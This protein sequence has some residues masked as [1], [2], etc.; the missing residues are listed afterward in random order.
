MS[1]EHAAPTQADYRTLTAY[2]VVS[3]ASAA[4]DFYC[5]AF[6][7]KERFR[8]C[9]PGG[10]IGHAEIQIGDSILMLA[11]EYPDF[12]AVGPNTLGGSPVKIQLAVDDVDAVTAH[13]VAAGATV[14]RPAKTE[15][16]GHR[17]S[18]LACPFGYSWFISTQV[19][20]VSVEQMQSRFD[21]MFS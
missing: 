13:A 6:G 2:I 8:L 11:D 4:I 1:T 14:L 3:D 7:A 10:K 17:Q 15:F 12:G 9:E 5:T 21:K 19:E 20:S 16:H 18:L